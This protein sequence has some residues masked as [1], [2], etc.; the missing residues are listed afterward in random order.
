MTARLCLDLTPEDLLALY[1]IQA[2]AWPDRAKLPRY[3]AAPRQALPVVV[4]DGGVRSVVAMRWG[5]PQPWKPRP[6]D[7]PPLVNA[8]CETAASK[9]TW[10]K[11]LRERR[12]I[13]PCTGFYEWVG[14]GVERTP[15]LFRRRDGRPLSLAAVWAAFDWD[16]RKAWPCVSVLTCAPN[17]TVAPVHDR[18]PVVVAPDH[19]DA[20]LHGDYDALLRPAADDVL[21][22][23]PA[24]RR[25]NHVDAE[26]PELLVAD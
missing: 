2:Q 25:L 13:V 8:Q 17:A 18:M 4:S 20:W 19:E 1:H 26:G 7:A 14:E 11:A 9:P 6:F 16:E 15:M 22:A 24:S 5:F 21:V 23:A 10:S 12:A 3:N